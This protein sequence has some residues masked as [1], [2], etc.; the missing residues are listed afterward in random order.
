VHVLPTTSTKL[1]DRDYPSLGPQTPRQVLKHGP[2][3]AIARAG[4]AAHP[5]I[6]SQLYQQR[7]AASMAATRLM[8]HLLQ[9]RHTWRR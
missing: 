7:P 9:H 2:R 6:D 8:S 3:P 5:Y 4:T 1:P